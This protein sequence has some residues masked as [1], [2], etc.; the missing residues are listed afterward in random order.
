LF[1][2]PISFAGFEM[3]PAL[4]LV[5]GNIMA[6]TFASRQAITLTLKKRRALTP[7]T[8]E[9]I[10]TPNEPIH[11]TAGQYMEIQVPHKKKDLR[12]LRRSFSIT[13]VPG[14]DEVRFGIKYYEP[15]SSFK[16]K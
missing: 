3:T 1:A 15:S 8:E 12:G 7:T 6:A 4:A 10:F 14:E 2:L 11:F 16:K 9:L 13:S 5:A